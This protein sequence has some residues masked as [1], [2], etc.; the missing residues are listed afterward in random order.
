MPATA[1]Q[2]VDAPRFNP[3]VLRSATSASVRPADQHAIRSAADTLRLLSERLVPRRRIVHAGDV[4]YSA[5]E[6]FDALYVLNSGLFKMVNLAAD[7]REQV[8]SLK[9]RG[10]WLGF[11]GIAGGAYTCDAV[12]MDTGEVWLIRYDELLAASIACPA[13]LSALHVAMSREIGRDRD[14]LMSVCTLPADARV[15]EFLRSWA[16][17]L[18]KSGMRYDQITLRMT[19]AEIGN[20]L[21]MTLETVS[22]ALSK[23]ARDE[24]IAFAEKG[25]RDISIP[26]VEAL[27]AFIQRC[28]APEAMLQ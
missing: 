26:D 5:G 4:V 8:V 6:R 22:R 12:A 1:L 7:G 10:D 18:A 21:G 20:Y 3:A 13:L 2:Q 16:D 24:V 25:R 9:F 14:S 28:L 15:A 23:L 17:S 19:R 11:D 27:S